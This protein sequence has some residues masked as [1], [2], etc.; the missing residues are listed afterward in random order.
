MI[1]G[2]D[3]RLSAEPYGT[4]QLVTVACT[5]PIPIAD[6]G[7]TIISYDKCPL[8]TVGTSSSIVERIYD[9][10]GDITDEIEVY[11]TGIISSPYTYFGYDCFNESIYA[12]VPYGTEV[13]FTLDLNVT[14]AN[15]T[16]NDASGQETVM[17][18]I[19]FEIVRE[20]SYAQHPRT[21]GWG[22][23]D[24]LDLFIPWQDVR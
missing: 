7:Y 10:H 9:E 6:E 13:T 1:T 14:F 20:I 15:I 4:G 8:M 18:D 11:D 3:C 22:S 12:Q 24:Q 19:P 16:L 21:G 17:T 2:I 5:N 23:E